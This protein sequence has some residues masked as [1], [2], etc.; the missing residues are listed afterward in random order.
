MEKRA[1]KDHVYSEV[2]RI[3]KLFSN[4]HRLEIIDLIANGPKSVED[5]AIETGISIANASQHLQSLKKERLVDTH[6]NGTRIFYTLVSDQVYMT[7][8]SLRDLALSISPYVQMTINE[9][10]KESGYIDSYSLDPLM[11]REDLV[12][13]D[14][15]PEDEFESGHI[16]NALSIPIK[17][18]EQKIN[19]IPKDKLIIA[20]CRGMFCT[21][22]DE[23]VQMLNQKGF[24]AMKLD[25]SVLEYQNNG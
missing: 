17:D 15:R 6:R 13:I 24:N 9:F 22:A 1:F 18:L 5:I 14:V 8:K 11:N 7:S 4:P 23:A 12:F 2:S 19:D 21:Y 10:K 25:Q 20:Y 16:P 3:S